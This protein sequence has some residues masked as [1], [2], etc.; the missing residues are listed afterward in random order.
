MLSSW[1]LVQA[2]EDLEALPQLDPVLISG[3]E[4]IEKPAAEIFLK[5]CERA[6]VPPEQA[7]HVGDELV[8]CVFY[9]AAVKVRES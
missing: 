3:D 8:W 9:S 2:L 4:G 1:R 5:A 7:L 6:G